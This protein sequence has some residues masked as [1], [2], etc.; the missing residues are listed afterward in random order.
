MSIDMQTRSRE[1][2]LVQGLPIAKLTLSETVAE[3]EA[4]TQQEGAHLVVTANALAAVMAHDNP[5]ILKDLSQASLITADGAGIQWALERKG[6]TGV[7]KVTGVDLVEQ[8][9]Q[10]SADKGY[11]LYFLGGEPGVAEQAAEKLRLKFPGCN[12]VGTRHG[13]FPASDDELVA[14]EVAEHR[15]DILFVAMGMPRQ[16][17]F[18]LK[19]FGITRAPVGIGVGGSFDVFSGR[20]RRAPILWQRLR[21]EWLWRALVSPS[22]FKRLAGLPRF[23]WLEWRAGKQGKA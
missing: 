1:T 4:M 7:E 16:E 22:K 9:C 3:I 8:L 19:T 20:V 2:V 17:Q 11:R 23:M 10:R 5:E 14:A 13:F 6:H 18:Y 21:V 15:P 12:I